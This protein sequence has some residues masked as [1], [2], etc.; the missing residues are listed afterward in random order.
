MN[1]LKL[2]TFVLLLTTSVGFSQST[3]KHKVIEGESIYAIAKK[4]DVKEAAIYELNPKVKGKLLKLNTIL[5]IPNKKENGNE[6]EVVNSI[7]TS[8]QAQTHVIASG[9]TLYEIAKKYK[10]SNATLNELN[11][12]LN[13]K[14]LKIGTVLK[15]SASETTLASETNNAPNK[16]SIIGNTQ[17]MVVLGAENKNLDGDLF[18][19]VLPRETKSNISKKY[20]I[21]LHELKR[22]N[23]E[24]P[25]KLAIGYS[26]LIKKGN[27][28][29][30]IA[31]NTQEENTAEF[32]SMSSTIDFLI[33]EASKN[34]GT[35]YKSGG[36][37]S[38]GFDCSGLIFSTFKEINKILP[39][40][41]YQQAKIGDKVEPFQAKKGDLIFFATNKKGTISHVGIITEILKDEIKFIH[42]SSSLGVIISSVKEPYYSKRF[43][44]I[45]RVLANT[46]F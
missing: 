3:I 28:V 17:N 21:T 4:Y 41:S 12:D 16:D 36:T 15:V 22:L 46:F 43:V 18:H 23:P 1:Y 29:E 40:A 34:L 37:T 27:P 38:K 19:K 9:E 2:F 25:D 39:R 20:G 33:K 31:T 11:P 10:I 30:E 32:A 6:K 44:Q 42:S 7:T 5:Q 45:N 24:A 14:R 8:A 26:L 13:P 35:R